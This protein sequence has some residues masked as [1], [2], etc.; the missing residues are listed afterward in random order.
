MPDETKKTEDKT[1]VVATV[2][3]SAEQ[4]EQSD[5]PKEV[6]KPYVFDDTAFKTKIADL[7]KLVESLAGRKNYNPYV[8]FNDNVQPIVTRYN[9]GERSQTMFESLMRIPLTIPPIDP[10]WTEEV[11]PK[12]PPLPRRA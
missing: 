11:I 6:I 12:G 4:V 3:K 5:S 10:N 7:N 2:A 9:K 8:W 1:P